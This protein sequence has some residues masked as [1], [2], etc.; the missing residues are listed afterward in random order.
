MKRYKKLLAVPAIIVIAVSVL[1][2][3]TSS[4]ADQIAINLI[5]ERTNI[6]QKSFYGQMSQQEAEKRLSHIQTYPL[7]SQDIQS[8]RE[9]EASELDIIRK[10]NIAEFEQEKNYLN[11]RTYKAVIYWDMTGLKDNYTLKGTY[12]V[13]LK[14]E[15]DQYKLSVFEPI[16]EE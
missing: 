15:N 10:M 7:L 1:S 12:H 5:K 3:F 2:G 11:Y 16:D 8:I 14:M 6:L 9:W 13:V 4:D